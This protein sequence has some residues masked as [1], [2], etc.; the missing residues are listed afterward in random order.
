[1]AT[2]LPLIVT[3]A[4]AGVHVTT[5]RLGVDSRFRGSD[6]LAGMTAVSRCER[7][8]AFGFRLCRHR[9]RCREQV[10]RLRVWMLAVL[11]MTFLNA[12]AFGAMDKTTQSQPVVPKPITVDWDKY[13]PPQQ[14]HGIGHEFL[15][16]TTILPQAQV[17][18]NQ[19][20][21]L[22]H[23]FWFFAAY[24]A[25]KYASQLDPSAA[26]TY[27][28][29]AE[30]LD[31]VTAMKDQRKAA[32]EKAKSLASKAS[33]HEQYYIRAQADL[34]NSQDDKA[35][36]AYHREME[37]LIDQ[38]PDDVN[39]KLM[40]AA[41][42]MG[43]YNHK[44]KPNKGEMYCQALLADILKAHPNDAAANHYWIHALEDGPH[45][46][47]ALKS[48]KVL[49]SLAPNS[50][51]MVHM[52]GHIY[53]R[54]GDYERARQS[55]LD[56]MRVDEAYMAAQRIPVQDDWNY[57]HNLSYLVAADAETG[58]Y[59]EARQYAGKLKDLPA[60][61]VYGMHGQGF[62][63][64]VGNTLTRLDL[65][66][67]NWQSAADDPVDLGVSPDVSTVAAKGYPQG[68]KFYAEGMVDIQK[69]D[70]EGAQ[71]KAEALDALLW[72]VSDPGGKKQKKSAS[73]VVKRLSVFSVELRSN[74]NLAQGRNDE[75]FRLLN[76]AVDEE[77]DLGYQEPPAFFRPAIEELG[78]AYLK[79]KEWDKARE[80]FNR[81]L[82]DR[83]HS[84]FA[85][86]FIAQSY[87][88]AGETNG[89]VQAYRRFLA[90]WQH[91]D[92]SLAEVKEAKS[93]L[94]GHGSNQTAKLPNMAGLPL[95]R[96]TATIN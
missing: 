80:A 60:A 43:G 85:L 82:R 32:I 10:M 3:P 2:T 31:P 57:G 29:M 26:M 7:L 59:Q 86:F 18:F 25:F 61:A 70:L 69:G 90:S 91:A 49:A 58:R 23:C 50:G 4:Q 46:D 39:A 78:D 21:N 38:Y 93:Y 81:E 15:Q 27:W 65:R 14:I 45:A 55:F 74:I 13:S 36:A 42:E 83:L 95:S 68:L 35:Q 87:A 56:S 52:P 88:L 33:D 6:G 44:G 1:M 76:Q 77:K 28:G 48:A 24:R 54:I 16:I 89:A 11:L 47:R 34:E 30:A 94:A 63:L 64:S 96:N 92:S 40:L 8:H 79:A 67:A 37:A 53:Y 17:Y 22:L 66:F 75:A 41:S 9:E 62:P 72:R 84:G 73:P 71:S 19:G 5:G 20:L 12:A 51:H